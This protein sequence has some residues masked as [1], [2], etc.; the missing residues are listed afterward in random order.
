MYELAINSDTYG[1]EYGYQF[2]SL[3]TAWSCPSISANSF[4]TNESTIIES[5]RKKFVFGEVETC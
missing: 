1:V 2:S 3:N 5:R 4:M